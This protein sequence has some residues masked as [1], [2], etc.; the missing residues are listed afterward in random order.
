MNEELLPPTHVAETIVEEKL[1][2]AREMDDQENFKSSYVFLIFVSFLGR[3]M[4]VI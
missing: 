2:R 1:T 3:H 4:C